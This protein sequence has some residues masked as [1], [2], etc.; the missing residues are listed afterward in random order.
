MPTISVIAHSI[1]VSSS[2]LLNRR[3]AAGG[4]E[5]GDGY[6]AGV[7]GA[8]GCGAD[9]G[10]TAE[11]GIDDYLPAATTAGGE[12]ATE[13]SPSRPSGHCSP[14]RCGWSMTCPGTSSPAGPNGSASPARP[15]P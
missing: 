6:V 1:P 13:R 3:V 14:G 9:R 5:T 11:L 2:S 12:N 15:G 8:E 10:A 7:L 4:G